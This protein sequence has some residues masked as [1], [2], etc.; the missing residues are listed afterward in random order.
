MARRKLP[1]IEQMSS[2][3]YEWLNWMVLYED[4]RPATVDRRSS[5]VRKLLSYTDIPPGEFGPESFDQEL[6]EDTVLEMRNEVEI[7]D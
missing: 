7:A 5:A 4:H 3:F 6:L 1:P 2:V